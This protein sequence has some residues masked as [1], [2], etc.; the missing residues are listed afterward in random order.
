MTRWSPVEIDEQEFTR[1]WNDEDLT[2][3]EIAARLGI[4]RS[5]LREKAKEFGL[6]AS[7]GFQP[8]CNRPIDPTPQEIEERCLEIQAG[9]APERFERGRG[10]SPRFFIGGRL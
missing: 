4:G 10:A 7:R 1:L 9:W 3:A 5:T 6:P 2:R 8:L